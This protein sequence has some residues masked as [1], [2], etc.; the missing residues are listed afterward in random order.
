MSTP[1]RRALP[2]RDFT[3]IPNELICDDGL[4][5]K[6]KWIL[7]YLLSK[8]ADWVGYVGDIEH[9]TRE[10]RAAVSSGMRE[11]EDAGLLIRRRLRNDDGKFVTAVAADG[12]RRHTMETIYFQSRQEAA[13]YRDGDGDGDRIPAPA[14]APE[15]APA[16]T[17]APEAHDSD[18]FTL[19]GRK[20]TTREAFAA[21][22]DQ[23]VSAHADDRRPAYHQALA[24]VDTYCS[25]GTDGTGDT[26]RFPDDPADEWAKTANALRQLVVRRAFDDMFGEDASFETPIHAVFGA[27]RPETNGPHAADL[28]IGGLRTAAD[29]GAVNPVKYALAR[30]RDRA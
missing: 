9:H 24:L 17:T 15:P 22:L 19:V 4:S 28:L 5:G 1:I 26:L 18:D 20:R 8:P 21:D 29:H 7:I 25:D 10:G 16:A 13:D 23:L 14:P 12:T 2:R 6:A 27:I 3:V 30:L 11:L